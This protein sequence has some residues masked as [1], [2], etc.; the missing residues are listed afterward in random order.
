MLAKKTL[1]DLLL[2][3]FSM[4]LKSPNLVKATKGKFKEE[5]GV[6]I[7][8][9]NPLARLSRSETR[10]KAF[11]PLG[12]FLWYMAGSDELD[13]IRH[14]VPA[15]KKESRDGF[16]V[17]GAYGPR[18]IGQGQ[19]EKVIAH[20][21]G[22]PTTRKA[23]IQ[24]FGYE[25]ILDPKDKIS[26]PCT[27]SFQFLLRDGKLG[28]IVSMRS[29]DA[30]LGLSHD[31]FCFTMIQEFVARCLGVEVGTY[32]HFVGSL[33]LYEKNFD[34]AKRFV[35]EG[36]QSTRQHMAPMPAG[37]PRPAIAALIGHESQ[38]RSNGADSGLLNSFDPYWQD[39]GKLLLFHSAKKRQAVAVAKSIAASLNDPLYSSY[40]RMKAS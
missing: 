3:V 18:L 16:T 15:Y 20:L 7:E 9:Q 4:L 8:L 33:H 31:I 27:C 40:T 36:Y 37:N 2:A 5:V 35:K 39:L 14:Y 1:D 38:A 22:Q 17:I 32:K 21:S 26:P 23:V 10:G 12:E 34:E 29:N 30:Y 28:L 11:S 25:D 19:L 6:L 13:F 24:L